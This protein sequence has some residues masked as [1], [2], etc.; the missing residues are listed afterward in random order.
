MKAKLDYMNI[1][2]DVTQA[3]MTP[4]LYV[5]RSGLEKSLLNLVKLR[6]SQINGCAFC[7]DMHV[8]EAQAAGESGLRLHLLPA[9]RET[10]IY[11]PRERAALAWTEALTQIDHAKADVV[12]DEVRKHFS[13]EEMPKLALAI[14]VIN[15]WN[16][17]N[18][19][20]GVTVAAEKAAA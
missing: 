1:A 9:W 17:F 12:F 20:F 3:L 8:R 10:D 6:A 14:G 7:I 2:P 16:R 11:T 18:I 4:S 5:E 15:I 13:D 19:A